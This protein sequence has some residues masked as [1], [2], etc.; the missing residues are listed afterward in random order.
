MIYIG[1]DPDTQK[2]GVCFYDSS[3]KIVK[4]YSMSFFELF[5]MLTDVH[6]TMVGMDKYIN[7]ALGDYNGNFKVIIEA[8]WLNTKSNWHSNESA[9]ISSRIGAKTGANHETGKKIV[10][11]MEY[12]NVPYELVKPQSKKVDSK[13]FYKLTGI[14]KSN[15]DARDAVMLVYGR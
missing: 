12:L 8:G 15:Q 3:V 10:E 14:K 2:S 4:M 5:D 6:W 1:I 7:T 9:G 11:M 13:F